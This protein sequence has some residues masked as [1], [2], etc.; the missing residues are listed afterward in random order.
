MFGVGVH[1]TRLRSFPFPFKLLSHPAERSIASALFTAAVPIVLRSSSLRAAG[2]RLPAASERRGVHDGGAILPFF[3]A[4]L[5]PGVLDMPIPGV[6]PSNPA[7][8][9]RLFDA[10]LESL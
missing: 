5:L 6:R 7:L 2:V 10:L 3:T 9:R 4:L 8:V 1:R